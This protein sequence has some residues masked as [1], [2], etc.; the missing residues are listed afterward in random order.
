[1][2]MTHRPSLQP[3]PSPLSLPQSAD[4]GCTADVKMVIMW[5]VLT[6]VWLVSYWVSQCNVKNLVTHQS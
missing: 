2:M 5:T 4:N 3:N 6:A 1:M